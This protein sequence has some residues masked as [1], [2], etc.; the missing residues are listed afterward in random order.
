M[1]QVLS[2]RSGPASSMG[3]KLWVKKKKK[4][5]NAKHL[6]V[7]SKVPLNIRRGCALSSRFH[8]PKWWLQGLG[9]AAFFNA[10][11][12]TDRGAPLQFCDIIS[13]QRMDNERVV[14]LVTA[15]VQFSFVKLACLSGI[16]Q[17]EF[18]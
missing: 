8:V 14:N 18:F 2:Q 11:Q 12:V 10:F 9:M 3:I 15:Y 5:Q 13:P 17:T 4:K 16:F 6:S 7:R 1:A